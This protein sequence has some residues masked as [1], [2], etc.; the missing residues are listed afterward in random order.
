MYFNQ[1]VEKYILGNM[2][3]YHESEEVLSVFTELQETDFETLKHKMIW[4]AAKE[5]AQDNKPCDLISV[6]T[7]LEMNKI[8]ASYTITL[9]QEISQYATTSTALPGLIEQMKD[10]RKRRILRQYACSIQ[11]ALA[12]SNTSTGAMDVAK[13]FP[14]F[15]EDS[16]QMHVA[17]DLVHKGVE[18]ML[19]RKKTGNKL[20]GITTGF[21]DIDVMTAGLQKKEMSVLGAR[22]SIGKSVFAF[23]IAR[24]AAKSGK[25]VVFFSLEMSEEML[26]DRML[27]GELMVKATRIKIPVLLD[28]EDQRKMNESNMVEELTTLHICDDSSIDA[29]GI[30]AK[31][32]EL[33]FKHGPIDLVI[34]DYLQYMGGDRDKRI[35]VENNSMGLKQLA[36]DIDAHVMCISSLSRAS[37]M[38][39]DQRP[40]MSDLR[41]SGQIEFDADVIMLM[42]RDVDAEDIETRRITEINFAKQRNGKTGVVKLNFMDDY[43]TFKSL[44]RKY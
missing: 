2:M 39:N 42:H 25:R 6:H 13:E 10:L 33:M 19:E 26:T 35:R 23:D 16:K 31:C 27:A 38:R 43:V 9:L 1:N 12:D 34:V 28:S 41:E 3:Y 4:R 44:E 17:S 29:M 18:R 40:T 5:L 24:Y 36:K 21:S 37:K 7:W 15:E 8:D 30:R 14:I 20:K 11:N 22:P 32:K